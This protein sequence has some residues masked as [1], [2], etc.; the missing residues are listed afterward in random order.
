MASDGLAVK[1]QI[2]LWLLALVAVVS[3]F[4][5]QVFTVLMEDI[6]SDLELN[7]TVLG[8]ISGLVFGLIYAVVALP[9]ARLADRHDRPLIIGAC[10]AVWSLATAAC[11]IVG[12]AWQ[13][14]IARM[15]VAA[16][17]AGSGP[18][19][20]SLLTEI[21]PPERRV[22][23]IG[24][25]QAAS[26]VG[27]SFGVIVAAWLASFL[28]W[29]SVFL[30]MGLPGVLLAIIVAFQVFEP[31]RRNGR[32]GSGAAH[33]SLPLMEALRIMAGIPALRWIA[34]LCIAVPMAGFGYLM[35]GPSFLQR[36]HGFE[37][38]ELALLGYAIL[39]G[40]V[41]GNL[42]AGWLGD[43]YGKDNPRFNGWLSAVGLLAAIPFAL[44]FALLSD[45]RLA[46]LCF[47]GLKFFMTLWV[48]PT[49]ALVFSLVPAEMRATISAVFNLFIILAGVGL[50]TMVVGVL[51]DAYTL[52]FG[53][54][55]IRYSLV[56]MTS[57]LAIG[58]FAA[59][60]A[61][62]SIMRGRVAA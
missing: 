22:L 35:W 49:L 50:G 51:S 12:N 62:R 48:P 7:D 47:V 58:A 33:A 55:A 43:R 21:F 61:A 27:L 9:I 10:L 13:M 23:V 2:S 39:I 53:D 5:R 6:K 46:L 56:T 41:A 16:G 8:L 44:G 4:D 42:S 17:E 25:M 45:A 38:S 29:R 14:A 59:A 31:R 54:E 28:P 36:V 34:L 26:S 11:A 1:R 40:L 52:S 60:M 30:V 3:Y 19:S 37:K 15:T 24:V 20:M 32:I 18:A 57:G